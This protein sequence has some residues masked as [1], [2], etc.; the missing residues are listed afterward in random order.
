MLYCLPKVKSS[1]YCA[2][3][4]IHCIPLVSHPTTKPNSPSDLHLL[5]TFVNGDESFKDRESWTPVCLPK[6]NDASFLF[7]HI[8]FGAKNDQTDK[9]MCP[10][11]C[12]ILA[13]ASEDDF[14]TMRNYREDLIA[15][16]VRQNALDLITAAVK[17][18]GY[19]VKDIESLNDIQVSHFL[20]KNGD[21]HLMTST[22]FIAPYDDVKEQKRLYRIY[23]CAAKRIQKSS[24]P[25]R[26]YLQV[27]VKETVICWWTPGFQLFATFSPFENRMKCIHGCNRI[28]SWI[29]TQENVIFM[30][31][32]PVW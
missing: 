22:N 21:S 26:V 30:K 20:Y 6:F 11:L 9:D 32:G 12:V 27:G 8:S 17:R 24:K 29:A 16:M 7:L 3:R 23:E 15:A 31:D 18:K 19:T 1:K 14:H 5:R 13:S 4:T 25:H 2:Q 28:I 10:K